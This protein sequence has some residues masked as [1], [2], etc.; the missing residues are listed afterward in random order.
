MHPG[1]DVSRPLEPYQLI[2]QYT[3]EPLL[4]S[5]AQALP[6]VTVRYGCEFLSLEQDATG[7]PARVRN[8]AGPVA[9]VRAAYLVGCDG[10][11]SRGRNELRIG[12][13]GEGNLLPLRQALSRGSDRYD[14][15]PIG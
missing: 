7:V 4:K 9:A 12:L 10:G 5:V 15:M 2:S 1:P 11:A 6:G 14:P 8:G 3:L 13:R